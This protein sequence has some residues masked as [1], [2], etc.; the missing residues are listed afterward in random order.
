[1]TIRLILA[2]TAAALA[3]PAAAHEYAVGD[4]TVDHP[5]A[6]ETAP[7]A[8]TGAGYFTITNAGDTPQRLTGVA[9]DF[10]QVQMHLSAEADGV[11][12]MTRQEAIE[13]PAQGSVVFAPGGYHVMFMGLDAD[14]LD[15]GAEF[16]LTLTFE[17]LDPLTVSVHVESRDGAGEGM[18]GMDHG[19]EVTQ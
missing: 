8:R 17:G 12:T 2:A 3:T 9:A 6:Y 13:I 19:T 14:G 5:I 4:L 15:V 10:P 11:M 7:G 1:M 18:E 16:P